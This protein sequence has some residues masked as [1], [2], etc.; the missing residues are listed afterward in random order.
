MMS[1][2]LSIVIVD[3]DRTNLALMDMLAR[4]LPNC[5]TQLFSHPQAFLD[6]LGGIEFD[7]AVFDWQ[8]PGVSGAEL[9]RS[10]RSQS[11]LSGKPLM[12]VT[13]GADPVTRS[14]ALKAGA[15]DVLCRPIRPMEFK[16][17]LSALARRPG[18]A[19]ESLVTPDNGGATR[20][21]EEE[22]VSAIA[23]AA[24]Y[25]DRETPLHAIRVACYC[26]II[27]HYLGLPEQDC[28]DLR[29]AAPLHDIGK[30]G[31]RDDVLQNRGFLSE[32]QRKH[33]AEHTR[34][35]HAI[36]SAGQTRVLRLAA[37]IALTHHERWNGTGYPQ[38]L[39]GEQIPLAGRI[40]AV[41]DVFDALTSLRPYKRAW[42]LQHA[43]TYLY[44]NAGTQFD[45]SC[46]AAFE[47][48]REDVESIMALMP[49]L[50]EDADAA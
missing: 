22:M 20:S 32:E 16:S 36:L 17:R 40:A 38:G 24:G 34:I 42:S 39:K 21:V 47:A 7:V 30:V 50:H 9:T 25:K 15:S 11:R 33:M 28:A 23:R 18:A 44:E 46:I 8:M 2:A 5:T 26:A 19:G 14:N 45:P 6:C 37:E 12:A 3:E 27:G 29:L 41:A 43:F 10:V 4:K 31:L 48:G 1:G 35:G 49:D 13:A